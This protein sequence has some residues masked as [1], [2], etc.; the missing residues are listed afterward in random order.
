MP[1]PYY[2]SNPISPWI[3]AGISEERAEGERKARP[4]IDNAACTVCH[5][6]ILFCPDGAFSG[7][8]S[9]GVDLRYC[10]GCGICAVEC[11]KKAIRIE[12]EE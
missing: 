1:H 9:I 12:A 8:E 6:C 5:L 4:V 3:P 7:G 10:R 2:R 11:P